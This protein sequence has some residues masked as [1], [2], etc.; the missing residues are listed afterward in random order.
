MVLRVLKI[1][2]E[3][4]WEQLW[5]RLSLNPPWRSIRTGALS[6]VL[7]SYHLAMPELSAANIGAPPFLKEN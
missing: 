5:G 6:P 1:V 3:Y 4:D 7:V 2:R